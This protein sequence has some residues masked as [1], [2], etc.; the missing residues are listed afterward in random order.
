MAKP[1][2][3]HASRPA[4]DGTWIALTGPLLL[5][6]AASL[7][8]IWEVDYWW[9]LK[10]GEFV[11]KH[12]IPATDVFSYTMN[13]RPWIELR[14]LYCLGLHYLVT[15]AGA[16]A[17]IIAKAAILLVS[18]AL[19]T[20]AVLNRRNGVAAAIM[21]ML[22]ILAAQQRFFVRPELITY[23][24]FGAYVWLIARYRRRPGRLI[25]LLPLLQ[26][27]WT[28][29]HTT[30]VLGPVVVGLLLAAM[31]IEQV[32]D[33]RHS[34]GRLATVGG[35]VAGTAA[36]CF[37]NPYGLE[38]VRFPF[39][40]L[41]QIRGT[42]FKEHISE[43]RSPFDFGSAYTA[44]V[45]YEI[46]IAVCALVAAG[47]LWRTRR[48]D[49]FWTLLCLSQLYL[50][51]LAIRNLPLFALAAVPFVLVHLPHAAPADDEGGRTSQGRWLRAVL[52]AGVLGTCGVESW[53]IVTDRAAAR[54][55]DTNQFGLG[56]AEHRFPSRAYRFLRDSQLDGR[57][58]ATMA[59]SS[60][61]L[62][63][64]VPVFFDPRLEVY[65]EA[66]FARAMRIQQNTTEW[67]AAAVE[68]GFQI[69]LVEIGSSMLNRLEEDRENWRL[70]YFDDAAAIYL[71]NGYRDD[72]PRIESA[73]DF[74]RCTA[75]LRAILA[76]PT[77]WARLGVF[78]R[79]RSAAY[80]TRVA[81]ALLVWHQDHLAAPFARD[82]VA[83]NPDTAGT[84][85]VLAVALD[86]TGDAAGA[87]REY[88]EFLRF[89]PGDAAIR[90][91]LATLYTALG[92]LEDAR[93]IETGRPREPID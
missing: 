24:M 39:Q 66:H 35:L 60:F 18:F 59:E 79:A 52:T 17:A 80:Y 72:L 89:Q 27:L 42:V 22:A 15:G 86:R 21:L 49:P 82:A 73:A 26:V 62:F 91:R 61:L 34:A 69:A 65:G 11:A 33:R 53:A 51:S 75:G 48:L 47:A 19:V 92:Q 25:W 4:R 81:Q 38:G 90:R 68:Y 40:L 76:P 12:G 44:V 93:R 67:R 83:A 84:H 23:L 16:A 6:V 88:E 29:A 32:V 28:N 31:L 46:L 9:Q 54:Q 77:P 3:D 55:G 13:G 50:S 41:S 57:V 45:Y 70:V 7:R 30:F 56:I 58:F 8:C 14:W 87:A 85:F 64:E 20:A 10:T 71:R 2:N 36:A 43:F 37:V 1:P 74:E 63:H 5:L 78:E